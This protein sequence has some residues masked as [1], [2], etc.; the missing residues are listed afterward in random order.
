VAS[1]LATFKLDFF[2]RKSLSSITVI[3][4]FVAFVLWNNKPVQQFS[5]T[6]EIPPVVFLTSLED[7]LPKKTFDALHVGSVI[8]TKISGNG[9][10]VRYFEYEVD[11]G[12]LLAAISEMPFNK[13][14]LIADTIC[15]KINY[16][17][18]V[19]EEDKI[20]GDDY[21]IKF[22]NVDSDEFLFYECIKPPLRHTLLIRKNSGRVIHRISYSVT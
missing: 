12:K 2:M 6:S 22:T 14:A 7:S 21:W 4:L 3:L 15:R 20:P 19:T 16:L 10:D 18:L 17:S 13:N 1:A 11:P 5:E 9:F 8:G